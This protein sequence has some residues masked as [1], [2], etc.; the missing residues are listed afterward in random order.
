M[1]DPLI[2]VFAECLNIDPSQLSDDSSPDNTP[3]WDSLAVMTLV[4]GI[5]ETFS[6]SLS[7]RDIMTMRSIGIARQVLRGKGVADV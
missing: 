5:E 7:T 6:I 2:K 4:A 3:L 1:T